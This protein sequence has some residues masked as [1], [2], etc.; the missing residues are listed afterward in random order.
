MNKDLEMAMTYLAFSGKFYPSLHYGSFPTVQPDQYKHVM[1]YVINNVLSNKYD[2]KREGS[3]IGAIRSVCNTWLDSYD[4]MMKK[5]SDEDI[6]YLIQQLHTRIKSFMKNIATEYYKAY[7]DKDK[8]L[9]YDS[10]NLNDGSY[11]LADSD[12]FKAEKVIEKTI[13]YINT[14]GT[15]RT[16][17]KHSS[18]S[19]IRADEIKS[20]IDTIMTNSNSIAEVRELIRLIVVTYFAQSKTKDI[21]D[22]SFVNFTLAPKPNAKNTDILRQ[23]EIIENWLETSSSAYRKRKTRL[24]TKNSYYKALLTYFTLC[25]VVANR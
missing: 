9:T 7:E 11:H 1:D 5:Y 23:K 25:V 15:N 10:D 3:V 20:I 6:C 16:L 21:K 19:N 2:I 18:D 17:C 8:Y 22:I 12:S 24:A 4:K 13:T 14:T